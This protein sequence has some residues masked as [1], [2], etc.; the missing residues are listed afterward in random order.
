MDVRKLIT[1]FRFNHKPGDEVTFTVKGGRQ[2]T[3]VLPEE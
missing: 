2:F 1:W 3:F